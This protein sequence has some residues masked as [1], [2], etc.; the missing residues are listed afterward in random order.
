MTLRNVTLHGWAIR[1]DVVTIEHGT[2]DPEIADPEQV[3]RY[4]TW[5]AVLVEV[6]LVGREAASLARRIAADLE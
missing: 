1:D 4:R 3:E 6:A 2:G 5:T